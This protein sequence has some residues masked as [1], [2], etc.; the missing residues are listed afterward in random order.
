MKATMI[1]KT[2][3]AASIALAMLAAVPGCFYGHDDHHDDRDH[4]DDADHR[5]GGDHHD[6]H[7]GDQPDVHV[8]VNH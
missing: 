1:L 4:R 3:L 2:T 6:D 5:D 8:D 7:H